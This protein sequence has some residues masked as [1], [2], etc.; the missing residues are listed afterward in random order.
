MQN[1]QLAAGFRR[2]GDRDVSRPQNREPPPRRVEVMG[3]NKIPKEVVPLVAVDDRPLSLSYMKQT[4]GA[5]ERESTAAAT[6]RVPTCTRYSASSSAR[7]ERW[8]FSIGPGSRI[9]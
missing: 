4:E 2:P 6:G 8:N 3:Q 1:V 9:E 5:R 7:G